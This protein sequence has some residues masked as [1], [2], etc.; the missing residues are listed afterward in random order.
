MDRMIPWQCRKVSILLRA[1]FISFE[2]P[3][4]WQILGT[5]ARRY[6][7]RNLMASLRIKI[8]KIMSL[9][10]AVFFCNSNFLFFLLDPTL[11]LPLAQP[12]FTASLTVIPRWYCRVL[13]LP[14]LMMCGC[15]KLVSPYHL[16]ILLPVTVD[17]SSLN[18]P[19]NTGLL[20]EGRYHVKLQDW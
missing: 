1:R 19:Q 7:P 12:C 13:N 14:L 18:S 5:P 11:N 20:K 17:Y 16:P 4:K 9:N 6:S 2:L 10:L 3:K 15:W 8:T